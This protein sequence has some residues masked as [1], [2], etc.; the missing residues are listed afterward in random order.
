MKRFIGCSLLL[1]TLILPSSISVSIASPSQKIP[2]AQAEG[3]Q[4]SLPVITLGPGYGVNIS[5]L[6]TG[7]TIFRAWLDD[8]SKISVDFDRQLGQGGA[9]IIHLKRINPLSL[10]SVARSESGGTLLTVVTQRG[11]S[12]RLY[13]FK[14]SLAGTSKY[15]LYRVTPSSSLIPLMASV[16]PVNQLHLYQY[17]TLKLGELKLLRRV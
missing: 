1:T 2:S 6:D 13:Q 15:T 5:F 4:G 14:I 8:P 10:P 7:D 16:N 9:S 17:L 11:T 3:K 12:K